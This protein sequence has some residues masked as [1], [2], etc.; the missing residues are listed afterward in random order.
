MREGS[1]ATLSVE[2]HRAFR[3]KM[4][5]LLLLQQMATLALALTICAVPALKDPILRAVPSWSW[6]IAAL[7]GANI[8][9]L[10][11]LALVRNLHPYNL[12]VTAL[13]TVLLAVT[14]VAIGCGGQYILIQVLLM[15]TLGTA[16]NVLL[17]T[18]LRHT[19]DGPQ[20]LSL[21]LVGIISWLGWLL[22][23]LLVF[24]CF[25]P[26][27]ISGTSFAAACLTATVRGIC[28]TA[29]PCSPVAL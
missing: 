22:V 24:Y 23:A 13:W 14:A 12:L 21:E 28:C 1:A 18:R 8:V 26:L 11:V 10:L 20:L 7:S 19:E 9:G 25:R 2:I 6:Q 15:C 5:M 16:L 4:L 3:F 27:E 29:V 17:G